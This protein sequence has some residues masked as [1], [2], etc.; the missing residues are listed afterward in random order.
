MHRTPC[1]QLLDAGLK[2]AADEGAQVSVELMRLYINQNLYTKLPTVVYRAKVGEGQ[3]F[4]VR[5]QLGTM[6]WSGSEAS[7]YDGYSAAMRDA[8][9]RLIGE[10]NARCP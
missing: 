9:T 4:I 6:S 2:D 5:S 3:P 7:V 10:L 8:N 1:A